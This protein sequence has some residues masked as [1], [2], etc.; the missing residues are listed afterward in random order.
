MS[1]LVLDIFVNANMENTA[2]EPRINTIFPLL[3]D[4]S[5]IRVSTAEARQAHSYPFRTPT[6]QRRYVCSMQR[7]T[8]PQPIR[9]CLLLGPL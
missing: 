2:S 8:Q 9:H 3:T 6:W 7:P 1:S 5:C 4:L